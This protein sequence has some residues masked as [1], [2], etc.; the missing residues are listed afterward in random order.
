MKMIQKIRNR[1]VHGL[2]ILLAAGLQ[3]EPPKQEAQ[4]FTLTANGPANRGAFVVGYRFALEAA[5]KI[6]AL[7]VVD[8]NKDGTLQGTNPVEVALWTPAGQELARVKIPLSTAATDG[9]FWVKIPPVS[10][11]AGKYVIGALTEPTGEAFFF[12]A[13]IAA[14][15]G[16]V[17]EEGLFLPSRSLVMPK[18][19]R[20]QPHGYF[21]PMFNFIAEEPVRESATPTQQLKKDAP[22]PA[23]KPVAPSALKIESPGEWSTQRT[24][25]GK[26]PGSLHRKQRLCGSE[27]C[28]KGQPENSH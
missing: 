3:A 4:A 23:E 18:M 22:N 10:L 6:T 21:G 19:S 14:S 25:H 8:Q 27:S 12:D 9:V 1:I 26:S 24:E 5:G 17:W 7:G 11:P 2:F 28:G 15:P 13:K 16:V 20:P